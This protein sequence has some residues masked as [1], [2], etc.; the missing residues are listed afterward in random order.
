MI[1]RHSHDPERNAARYVSG[2]LRRRDRARFEGHLLECEDCWREVWL[3]RA[4]RRLVDASREIAPPGLREDVSAAVGFVA[5]RSRPRLWP[6]LLALVGI[7]A[8]SVSGVALVRAHREPAPIASALAAYHAG[9]FTATGPAARRAPDLSTGGLLLVSSARVDLAGVAA[10]GFV[11]QDTSGQRVLLFL[12]NRSFPSARGA[13]SHPGG[14]NG[15]QAA[16]DGLTLVCGDRPLPYLL[17]AGNPSLIGPAER[18]VTGSI[19][20]T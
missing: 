6:V 5:P 18:L 9:T 13:V 2:E 10:D 12:S 11:Y 1:R 7:A 15:W 17:I 4:G 8:L 3:G 14:P 16:A 19:T 20:S